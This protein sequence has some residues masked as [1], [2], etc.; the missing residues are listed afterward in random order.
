ML[1]LQTKRFEVSGRQL[2]DY[3]TRLMT[4][5]GY[6]FMSSS[7]DF[8]FAKRI[9]EALCYVSPYIQNARFIKYHF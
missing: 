5:R 3:L 1:P 9:K 4:E 6:N 2:T 8:E 7:R